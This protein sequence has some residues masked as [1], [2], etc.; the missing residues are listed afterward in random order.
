M[1]YGFCCHSVKLCIIDTMSTIDPKVGAWH[2]WAGWNFSCA[3]TLDAK[4][5]AHLGPDWLAA[6]GPTRLPRCEASV[7]G[8]LVQVAGLPRGMQ[9][10]T[11]S[12]AAQVRS[13]RAFPRSQALAVRRRMRG[14]AR[15]RWK[16]LRAC[17]REDFQLPPTFRAIPWL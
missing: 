4:T 5:M 12:Q 13:N 17:W 1:L 11:P 14:R 16:W 6:Y 10:G 3:S 15:G 9:R 8:Y 7:I 2:L